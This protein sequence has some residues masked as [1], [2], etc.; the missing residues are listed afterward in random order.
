MLSL[1]TTLVQTWSACLVFHYAYR[2]AQKLL[3]TE[4]WSFNMP[5]FKMYLS[6]QIRD[7]EIYFF[8]SHTQ[9]LPVS[10]ASSHCSFPFLI[11]VDI[12]YHA[13]LFPSSRFCLPYSPLPSAPR[14]NFCSFLSFQASKHPKSGLHL[15]AINIH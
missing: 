14:G 12:R 11:T 10:P 13:G 1:S 6:S 5:I 7:H 3:K 9:V 8:L 15:F 2:L 4:I